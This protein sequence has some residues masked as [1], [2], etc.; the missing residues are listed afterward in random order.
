MLGKPCD[1]TI[2]NLS[3]AALLYDKWDYNRI[4]K[5]FMSVHGEERGVA[6]YITN[7]TNVSISASSYIYI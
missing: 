6:G 7:L 2:N 3:T 4:Y 1:S 5:P